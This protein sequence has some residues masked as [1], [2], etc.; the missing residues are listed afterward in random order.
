MPQKQLQVAY[1]YL[2]QMDIPGES[3]AEPLGSTNIVNN[4]STSPINVK[5]RIDGELNTVLKSFTVIT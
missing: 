4:Q 3:T 5:Y 1:L 2:I